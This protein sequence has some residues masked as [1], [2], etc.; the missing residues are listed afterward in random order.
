MAESRDRVGKRSLL[1]NNI[2]ATK[3]M[4]VGKESPDIV[5]I[6]FLHIY[7]ITPGKTADTWL[8]GNVQV[9]EYLFYLSRQLSMMVKEAWINKLGL[10]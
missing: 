5:H 2:N 7:S 10:T 8:S 9:V 3:D 1:A 6:I 4:G